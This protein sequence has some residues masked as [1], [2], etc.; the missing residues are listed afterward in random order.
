MKLLE[1][2][3]LANKVGAVDVQP[4]GVANS[5]VLVDLF[6]L[7]PNLTTDKTQG[8]SV[9]DPVALERHAIQVDVAV[10]LI[11]QLPG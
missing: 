6:I 2:R 3:A 8:W 11:S 4:G 10:D 9:E 7:L 1:G 5:L